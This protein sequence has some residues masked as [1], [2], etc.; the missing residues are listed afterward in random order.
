MIKNL[1]F[2]FAVSFSSAAFSQGN[3]KERFSNYLDSLNAHHKVMG[4]FAFANNDQP[5]FIK[6]TGFADAEK[7]QKANMN[8]QYR[9]GSISKT[10]TA[11]LVMKAAED[12]KLSLKAKLSDFFPEIA[13]ANQITI[14]N[15]LQHRSGIHNI[16]DEAEFLNIYTKSQTKDQLLSLIKKYPSDF[17]PGSKYSYSNSN[18][19]LLG[20][21]LEKVYKQSYA[22]LIKNKI[23]KPLKLSLTEVGGKINS[24]KNQAK[25]YQFLGIYQ[26][27]P[28]TDMSV[29]IGAGS[30]ISTPSD[31]LKFIIGLENGKLISKDN[32]TQMKNFVDNYGYGLI[33]ANVGQYHGF[34]HE[35][36]IDGFH[37]ALYYFP[38]SKIAVSFITNQ[39]SGDDQ[40][41]LT[42]MMNAASGKDFEMPGFKEI[43]VSESILKKYEGN[44]KAP[45]FPL[46]IKI[47]VENGMLNA[48]ATGQ[49]AFPLKAIS[50]TEFTFETAGIKTK[51]DAD[52]KTMQF[53]QG[54]NNITFT[55]Q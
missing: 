46:D 14:E 38:E 2:L 52:K 27:L 54:A 42:K 9:I 12:K 3:V 55:K 30:I 22:D 41:I 32:L 51:F 21:I 49:G 25:S 43:S 37:S 53:S 7:Q 15:L 11:V 6:V 1:Y 18:Y 24:N 8:T 33:K 10:F 5:T 26:P 23:S 47:F 36:A 39:S 40:D 16:T 19:I 50:E 31:L 4:S 17:A 28:E 35:G 34:G 29:P 48:Q 20:L 45:G 44:Y 13:N